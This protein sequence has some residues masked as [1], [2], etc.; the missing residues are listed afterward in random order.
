LPGCRFRGAR[1][2]SACNI[3]PQ[4]SWT[5]LLVLLIL[6][7]GGISVAQDTSSDDSETL[8][9]TVVNSATREPIPR[10]LVFSPDN[11]FATMTDM[12]G[13]F[14]FSLPASTAPPTNN[15]TGVN[16]GIVGNENNRP[17]MLT[18][19]KPG[20]LVGPENE[21]PGVQISSQTKDVTIELMPEALIVGHVT[22]P[23]SEPPDKI[24][25]ELYKR[26][27]QDGRA[28]WVSHGA[29]ASFSNGE[30]RFAEL[31]A[32][33]YKLFTRELSDTDVA[34]PKGQQFAYTPVYYPNASDFSSG[35]EIQL[36]AGKTFTA[37]LSLTR[38]AYFP[39]RVPVA[40]V[41]PGV[42]VSVSVSPQGR[43]GPGYALDYNAQEQSIEGA[44]PNGT[45]VLDV[46]GSGRNSM[47][48]STT[49]V[50]RGGPVDGPGLVM[51]AGRSIPVDVREEFTSNSHG[52]STM[53]ISIEGKPAFTTR[54]LRASVS[55]SLLPAEDF[56]QGG[57]ELRP[58]SG[59][60]DQ[61]LVL[62]G[63]NPG[64]YWVRIT[65]ARG[66]VAAMTSGAIDLMRSPLVVGVGGTV[67]PIEVTLRD[68]TAQLDGIVE[69]ANS[70]AGDSGV[71]GTMQASGTS[72]YVY[73]IPLDESSGQ[74]TALPISGDGKIFP[75]ALPP[76]AYRILA[77]KRAQNLEYHNPEAMR[78]LDGKGT[79][80]RLVAGQT[81]HVQVPLLASE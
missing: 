49:I 18:A 56:V 67:S 53:T 79:T 14:E 31:P 78:A 54:G 21:T 34:I 65:T 77:F 81:E 5:L 69:G 46:L 80:V 30:F 16:T 36:S 33:I 2:A 70:S 24:Q 68:D 43:R 52:Q 22:L 45:F 41:P 15:P 32:G 1:F 48:G 44:L 47:S 4:G 12:Q 61:S 6:L 59:P 28:H 7:S 23:S 58:P 74:F 42:A 38:Q 60:Q 19:R 29:T 66:Y 26:E 76:G 50:V 75:V 62:D 51:T 55:L 72:A 9:G 40:N 73:C 37:D 10:A 63:V 20:F 39:I 3:R 71:N 27:V 13:R 64:R 35:S 25:L 8:H 57:A 17:Y 11:R